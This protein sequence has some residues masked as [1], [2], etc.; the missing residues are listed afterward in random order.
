MPR[1]KQEW[2][3]ARKINVPHDSSPNCISG[4]AGPWPEDASTTQKEKWERGGPRG[5]QVP[6]GGVGQGGTGGSTKTVRPVKNQKK[7]KKR[8]GKRPRKTRRKL[9]KRA[10]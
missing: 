10:K 2:G 1:A 4:K 6:K 9:Q 8:A 3:T 7:K 5:N